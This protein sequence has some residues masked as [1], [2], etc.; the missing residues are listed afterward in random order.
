MPNINPNIRGHPYRYV[1]GSG[2][3]EQGQFANTVSLMFFKNGVLLH[4]S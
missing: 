2:G 3:Y 4:K 1:Y